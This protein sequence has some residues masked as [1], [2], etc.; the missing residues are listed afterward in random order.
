MSVGQ[1]AQDFLVQ[2]DRR[3]PVLKTAEAL[4]Q[5][6]ASNADSSRALL[7]LQERV[8]KY[9][10][11]EDALRIHEQNQEKW[12]T[13]ELPE[14]SSPLAQVLTVSYL[15]AKE[16][17]QKEHIPSP[18]RGISGLFQARVRSFDETLDSEP[19]YFDELL[20]ESERLGIKDSTL[21]STLEDAAKEIGTLIPALSTLGEGAKGQWTICSVKVPFWVGILVTV[22]IFI[23]IGV[24]L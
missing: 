9:Q 18:A 20:V 8:A 6:V 23:A 3:N 22:L 16:E 1:Q 14:I 24:P 17:L 5:E 2:L 7:M 13:P 10:F 21:A 4:A 15:R 11:S 19:H 12:T